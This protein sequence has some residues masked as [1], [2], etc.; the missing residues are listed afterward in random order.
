MSPIKSVQ[1]WIRYGT[2]RMSVIPP[3]PH[4]L[5][6]S[7]TNFEK[8][9]CLALYVNFLTAVDRNAMLIAAWQKVGQSIINVS[10]CLLI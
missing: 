5:P 8:K 1:V 9:F 2:V 3:P 10:N 4:N 7:S 6:R